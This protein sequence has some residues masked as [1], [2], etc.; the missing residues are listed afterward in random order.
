[1]PD[2]GQISICYLVWRKVQP[3]LWIPGPVSG[4]NRWKGSQRSNTLSNTLVLRNT[5]FIGCTFL[6]SIPYGLFPR[7]YQ[8]LLC[9]ARAWKG[10]PPNRDRIAMASCCRVTA[11][12]M[13]RASI[14]RCLHWLM[15]VSAPMAWRAR[16]TRLSLIVMS[17]FAHN[18]CVFFNL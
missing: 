12:R 1:M 9:R 3:C 4:R 16:S 10:W 14:C 5:R 13:S 2:F 11:R 17:Y 15:S 7:W 6:Y 18:T 8:H